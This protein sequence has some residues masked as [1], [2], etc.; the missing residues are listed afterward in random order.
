LKPHP[1]RAP[2]TFQRKI[3]WLT[4]TGAPNCTIYFSDRPERDAGLASPRTFLEGLG[5]DPSNPLSA[6]IVLGNE[7]GEEDVLV[8]ELMTPV[9]DAEATALTY[10]AK[11]LRDYGGRGLADLAQQ[12]TDYELAASFNEGSLFIDDC[13]NS[14]LM[15]FR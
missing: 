4:L 9:Y 6:A 7:G 15:L 11:V 8:M 1:R 5:F 13:P 3:L 10:E 2:S 14:L 12:Q